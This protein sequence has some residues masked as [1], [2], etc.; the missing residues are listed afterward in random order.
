M[1]PGAAADPVSAIRRANGFMLR[2]V[3]FI[4][5]LLAVILP[6][7]TGTVLG[8][9]ASLTLLQSAGWIILVPLLLAAGL[10]LPA[11]GATRFVRLADIAAA[12][13]GVLA[14]VSLIGS[15]FQTQG[16]INSAAS[17]GMGGR[18]APGMDQIMSAGLAIGAYLLFLA[19]IL[20]V[21]L[22][23]RGPRK[24]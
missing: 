14:S 6:G 7:T 16:Q 13:L 21:L 17:F 19:T 10:T 8:M 2:L 3:T 23:L 9:S 20:A 24:A 18:A 22:A 1:P 12:I 11:F 5:A 4:V 15:L